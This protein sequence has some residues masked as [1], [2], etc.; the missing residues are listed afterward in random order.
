MSENEGQLTDVEL[1]ELEEL[2]E[3]QDEVDND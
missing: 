2:G 1:D 3:L